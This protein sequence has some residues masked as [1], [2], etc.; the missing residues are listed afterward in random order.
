MGKKHFECDYCSVSTKKGDKIYKYKGEYFCTDCLY[1]ELANNEDDL[2]CTET[3]H[4]Y[5]GGEYIGN[6]DE[7]E[8]KDVIQELIEYGTEIEEIDND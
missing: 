1:Y 7:L 8:F 6:S 5:V 4:Y 3:T 2:E